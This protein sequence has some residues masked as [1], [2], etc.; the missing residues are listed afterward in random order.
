MAIIFPFRSHYLCGNF[1][2]DSKLPP[3][4]H[5]HQHASLLASGSIL[6]YRTIIKFNLYKN[7]FRQQTH[8]F[9]HWLNYSFKG[10][11]YP[12]ISTQNL[13]QTYK[14]LRLL[15]Y[16]SLMSKIKYTLDGVV[17]KMYVTVLLY[18]YSILC[19]N[20]Y[21]RQKYKCKYVHTINIS[22]FSAP[23]LSL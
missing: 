3:L 23:F 5:F 20:V 21:K 16:R 10:P 12:L 19:V 18:D 13:V 2:M 17:R 6:L 8:A 9:S 7:I 15:D 22:L 1:K 14:V 11:F 4:H